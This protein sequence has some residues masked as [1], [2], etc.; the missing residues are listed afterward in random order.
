[1]R[2]FKDKNERTGLIT[3]IMVHLGLFLIFLFT[4]LTYLEPPPPEEGITINFGTSNQGSGKIQPESVVSNESQQDEDF[5][6][7][8]QSVNSAVT[9]TDVT[10]NV[11]ESATL[12]EDPKQSEQVDEVKPDPKPD[13]KLVDLLDKWSKGGGGKTG[14]EGETGQPGDQGSQDGDRNSKS[15]VGS[16]SGNGFKWN[17]AGRSINR[18]PVIRDDSQEEGRVVVDIVVNRNGQVVRATPG[19]KGS[20][21]TSSYLY[22]LAKEAA[23]K[24]KFDAK[25][26]AAPQQKGQIVFTFLVQG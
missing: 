20:T 6:E 4:G 18:K 13:D 21:T 19:A 7:S 23:M 8:A 25:P 10:Q 5:S 17:L 22:R 1:M 24:T 3:T 9:T 16:G 2:K 11:E 12:S 14:S 26:D 15:H